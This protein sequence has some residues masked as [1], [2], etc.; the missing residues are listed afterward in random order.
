MKAS[1]DY[2]DSR[3]I[4]CIKLDASPDG[5]PVY[6]RTGFHTE[7]KVHRWERTGGEN[8]PVPPEGAFPKQ[9]ADLDSR[10]S[11]TSRMRLMQYIADPARA[12]QYIHSTHER[13]DSEE[14]WCARIRRQSVLCAAG[15]VFRYW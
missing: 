15:G 2:L 6:E 7:A 12:T 10:A 9:L 1:L 14:T 3:N 13:I 4:D 11:G 5:F 8:A